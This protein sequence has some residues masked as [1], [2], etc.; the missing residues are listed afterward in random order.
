MQKHKK[1]EQM[2]EITIERSCRY[3]KFVLNIP[4]EKR[5]KFKNK[6]KD[7][8]PD[9]KLGIDDVACICIKNEEEFRAFIKKVNER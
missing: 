7:Q 9:G 2:D 4:T 3:T 6:F 1:G 8:F 5:L